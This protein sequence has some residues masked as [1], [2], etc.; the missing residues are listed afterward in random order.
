MRQ[1]A[2]TALFTDC[3]AFLSLIRFAPIPAPVLT[4]KPDFGI[5]PEIFPFRE[6]FIRSKC[7]KPDM[8]VPMRVS[9]PNM[10]GVSW[11][12]SSASGS[13][14]PDDRPIFK[15]RERIFSRKATN[16]K[17][18][19]VFRGVIFALFFA[20]LALGSRVHAQGVL[21]RSVGPVNESMGSVA[22]GTPLDSAGALNWNPASISALKKSELSFGLGIILPET[23]VSSSLGSMSGST[24]GNAGS[25]PVPNMSFVWR[26]CPK[27]PITF[28]LGLSAVGGAA[29]LY[30]A[31]APGEMNPI[32]AQRAK[33]ATVVIL[34][35]T[36]TISYQVT[37][38]LSVGVA[39]L[40][41][42]ASLSINPMQLGQPL[43]AHNEIHNYGTRYAWGGGFQIGAFYDFK[44][45]WK[46]GFMFKSPIWAESLRFSGTR[47][48][49]DGEN[50]PIPVNGTFDLDLPMTLSF[51]VSY[52]GFKNTVIGMDVRYF[53]YGNTTGFKKGVNP[54]TGIVEGLDWE[55][56]MS[57]AVG[58][59]RTVNKKLKVRAG[60]CW[61]ENPIPSRSSAL[62]VA[63]PLMMQHTFS[64][65]ATYA[66]VKDLEF[67]L[68]YSHAFKAKITGPFASDTVPGL[69]GSVTNEAYANVL[70]AGIT[71]KW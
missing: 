30:A 60:Y 28:G 55:S 20:I 27:S 42:L 66:V 1:Y 18:T 71:K 46:T 38:K 26:R 50:R 67:S 64:V 4:R 8:C 22:T 43:G 53:D 40:I 61:N 63:A 37:D 45:H 51:G 68:A 58:V 49:L 62:N 7:R 29:S 5:F 70:M 25:I 14:A 52:D 56:V 54:T 19:I 15:H 9:M 6:D 48:G 57:V 17:A 31:D 21:L 32:L 2:K 16:M 3:I 41:D 59:E 44:N 39:P 35:V 10:E 47:V 36:P 33:S 24:K 23:R 65:G 34:Q 13:E 12:Y 11:L 69:V